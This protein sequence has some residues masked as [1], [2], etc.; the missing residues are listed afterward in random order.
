VN[1]EPPTLSTRDIENWCRQWLR[2]TPVETLFQLSHLSLVTG[3]ELD[4]GR[5]DRYQS[6]NPSREDPRLR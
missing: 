4:D 3:L 2:A 1:L 6:A 5:A